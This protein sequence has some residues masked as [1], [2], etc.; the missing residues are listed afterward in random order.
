MWCCNRKFGEY[1]ESDTDVGNNSLNE[2]QRVGV[3]LPAV[4]INILL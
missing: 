2:V 3:R 4:L 1:K